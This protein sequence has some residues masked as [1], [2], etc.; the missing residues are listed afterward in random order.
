M[1]VFVARRAGTTAEVR[2]SFLTSL[3]ENLT[4]SFSGS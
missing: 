4:V 3:L 2:E 1:A